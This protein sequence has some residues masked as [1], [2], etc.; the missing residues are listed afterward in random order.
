MGL[1]IGI[2]VVVGV[3]G[4]V[5]GGCVVPDDLQSKLE[6]V[7]ALKICR[8]QDSYSELWTYT[9]LLLLNKENR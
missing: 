7:V 6:V 1:V 9:N 2:Y 5:G 8:S 4:G 3:G